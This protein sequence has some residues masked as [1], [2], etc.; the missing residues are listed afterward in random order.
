MR[1]PERPGAPY[2][3]GAS[4]ATLNDLRWLYKKLLEVEHAVAQLRAEQL[5]LNGCLAGD[6]RHLSAIVNNTNRL[7]DLLLRAE[8]RM[9]KAEQALRKRCT[10]PARPSHSPPGMDRIRSRRRRGR[11]PPGKTEPA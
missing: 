2:R 1:D 3:P 10:D 6:R 9:Q 8:E 5:R 7:I 4:P 11:R